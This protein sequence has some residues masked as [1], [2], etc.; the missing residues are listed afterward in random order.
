MVDGKRVR[1]EL[2][3]QKTYDR[4]VGVC[5]LDGRDIGAAVIKARLAIDC[6]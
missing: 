4:F 5:Y 2:N 3:D 1:C 6:P